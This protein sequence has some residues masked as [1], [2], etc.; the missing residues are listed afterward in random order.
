LHGTERFAPG[1]L[2]KLLDDLLDD[3]VSDQLLMLVG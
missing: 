1:N 3:W 2:A